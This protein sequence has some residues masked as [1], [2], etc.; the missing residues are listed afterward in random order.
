MRALRLHGKF[1]LRLEDLPIPRQPGRALVRV[2]AVSIC[3][4]DLHN[5]LEGGTG[6]APSGQPFTLGHE[7]AGV[8]EEV[9]E[10]CTLP[11]G[12]L[13]AVDPAESCGHCRLCL[14]GYPNLCPEVRFAGSS[15]YDGGMAEYYSAAPSALIPLPEGMD[16]VSG[17]LL[18][19]LGVAIHAVGLARLR[20]GSRV[21]ILGAGPIGLLLLQVAR[22][23]GAAQVLVADP[24]PY[25]LEVAR[26][27]GASWVGEDAEAAR[28]AA[29][30]AGID[31][32]L[33]ATNAAE[34][35]EQ[36]CSAARPGGK[37]VLVGIPSE[38]R[39][40]LT[41]SLLRRKG[42]SLLLARRMGHTYPAA[43]RLVQAGSV[44]LAPLVSHRFPLGEALRAFGLQS[45]YR[46]GALKAVLTP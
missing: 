45:S 10:G 20:P 2:R 25:R 16:A 30:E 5:Y 37:V 6:G 7:F 24:L 3:G 38:D 22:A 29:G 44:Q 42:L 19:P 33:E 12:T 23:S 1:D 18:E 9:P 32:V 39:Y 43:I 28:R 26:E 34:A 21:L 15:P 8:L 11:P 14:S 27:L 40:Q 13:V 36:A 46:E 4:S 17:A 35:A 41:A 31:T